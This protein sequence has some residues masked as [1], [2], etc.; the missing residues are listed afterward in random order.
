MT[1]Y[2]NKEIGEV[3]SAKALRNGSLLVIC[4]DGGQQGKAIRISKINGKEVL[5]SLARDRN[6]IRGVVTGIPVNILEGD[7]KNIKNAIV[8]DSDSLSVM[9]TFKEEKLPEKIYIGYMCYNVRLY[10]PPQLR[11][12]KCQRFGRGGGVQGKAKMW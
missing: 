1:K 4:K 6:F 2:I 11:C 7:I 5:C 12:F 8:S 10:I 3:R 9:I